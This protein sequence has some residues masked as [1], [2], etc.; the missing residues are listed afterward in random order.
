MGI[1]RLYTG[2]DHQSHETHNHH[3]PPLHDHH[4][5]ADYDHIPTNDDHHLPAADDH[6]NNHDHTSA[7]HH[8]YHHHNN[9]AADY[10]HDNHDHA[11]AGTGCGIRQRYVRCGRVRARRVV[12]GERQRSAPGRRFQTGGRS[13][14]HGPVERSFYGYFHSDDVPGCAS[15][16]R[17]S[18][19]L[20]TQRYRYGDQRDASRSH[21]PGVIQRR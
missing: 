11:S 1:Y 12:G 2:D 17:H 13:H 3:A 9:P 10:H 14:C 8:Y 18:N 4:G 15:S 7:D 5:G 20:R 16:V 6:H 19:D 21:L